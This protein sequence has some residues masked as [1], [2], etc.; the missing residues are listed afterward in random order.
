MYIRS[1][2]DT[3]ATDLDARLELISDWTAFIFEIALF[4]FLIVFTT[5]AELR[6]VLGVAGTRVPGLSFLTCL[7]CSFFNFFMILL[8]IL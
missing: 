5:T 8:G 1:V 2:L 4:R 7:P 6:V 3:F